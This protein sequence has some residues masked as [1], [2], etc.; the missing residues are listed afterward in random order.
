VFI[1]KNYFA[2]KLF[3]ALCEALSNAFPDEA[4]E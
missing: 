1:P 3:A 2:T 4:T